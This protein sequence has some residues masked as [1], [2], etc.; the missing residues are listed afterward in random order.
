M[1]AGDFI[2]VLPLAVLGAASVVVMLAV[3]FRRHHGLAALLASAG[4]VLALAALVPAFGVSPRQ[5]T[6]LLVVDRYALFYQGLAIAA[7]LAVTVLS[8]DYFDR[9]EGRREELYVLLLLATL[10]AAV[11]AASTHFASLFLGLELLSVA[12]FA[13]IAYPVAS[14]LP[15]EAG[16]KYLILAGV[17][18]ALLLFGMALIYAQLGTLSFAAIGAQ[19]STAA[20]SRDPWLLAG[21]GLIVAGIGFKLSLVPFHLWA[22]DIYQGAPAPVAAFVATVSKGAVF[23]LLLRYFVEAGGTPYNA[24]LP[25]FSALAIASMLAG[26]LLALLQDNVKRILAYSSIAHLGYVL[27]AF[28]GSGALALEAVGYYLAAYFVTMLGAFGA[29]GALSEPAQEAD[30]ETLEAYRAL[31][32]QRPWLAAIFAGMLLSLA[33]IPLT[34]GFVAKFYVVATGVDAA[35]WWPLAALVIGSAIGLFY[36]LRII[37]VMY[38]NAPSQAPA[39]ELVPLR[40]GGRLVLAVLAFLLVGLGVFPSPLIRWIQAAAGS[41]V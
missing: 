23:A 2:A 33:G 21:M 15:L 20:H 1:T 34:M 5:V 38:S 35:T 41:L 17:S 31:G 16:A 18:S 29:V 14:H 32:W 22:P 30:C 12:L 27:V 25:V 13:M 24:L 8:Y 19:S 37:V 4:M 9:R 39:A 7:G 3:A 26:N 11:L 40:P 36:Y 6:P 10:G 28:T